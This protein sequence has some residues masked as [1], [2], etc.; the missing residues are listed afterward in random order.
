MTTNT[1]TPKSREDKSVD[2]DRST[3]DR[4]EPKA[5]NHPTAQLS[6]FFQAENDSFDAETGE[7]IES[8]PVTSPAN[9]DA[10]SV[11]DLITSA[12]PSA[13]QLI[14]LAPKE[15]L[16]VTELKRASL[17]IGQALA[18]SSDEEQASRG[19]TILICSE[20]LRSDRGHL[21]A[22]RRC[23]NKWCMSCNL[24]KQAKEVSRVTRAMNQY[25][26]TR[27]AGD[28]HHL[29]HRNK[30]TVVLKFTLNAGEACRLD[31]VGRRI[32][33]MNLALRNMAGA[34]GLKDEVIGWFRSTEITQSDSDHAHPH[35]H[36]ALL[37][38]L[39]S[40]IEQVKRAIRGYWPDRI[41]EL[42]K[43]KSTG[44]KPITVASV[45][46][47]DCLEADTI[48]HLIAWVRYCTKGSYDLV[49]LSRH[50]RESRLAFEMTSDT[51]WQALDEQLNKAQLIGFGGDLRDAVRRAEEDYKAERK[52]ER[53]QAG[54]PRRGR[55]PEIT[56]QDD[57]LYMH[58]IEGYAPLRE[59][60]SAKSI[61]ELVASPNVTSGRLDPSSFEVEKMTI[62]ADNP[63][64]TSALVWLALSAR[65]HGLSM[66]PYQ[67]MSPKQ[68]K[69]TGHHRQHWSEPEERSLDPDWLPI[70]RGARDDD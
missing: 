10:E 63:T 26:S 61:T 5:V 23:K 57:W 52:R 50:S 65:V 18:R 15:L 9:D 1:M 13:P 47:L 56:R 58:S 35:L 39:D 53:E 7:L 41:A 28:A 6:L 27:L 54:A 34:R 69:A 24:A 20:K 33:M 19:R 21:R 62:R 8:D 68:Y 4:A 43:D 66:R 30:Q 49:G 3:D 31:Q 59:I 32:K 16:T 25:M 46:S 40:D 42:L 60:L 37:L 17:K 45:Q 2:A 14:P 67:G 12:D 64:A 22:M 70:K 51:Y 11:R 48:E 38:R 44:L 55:P 29:T 36:G